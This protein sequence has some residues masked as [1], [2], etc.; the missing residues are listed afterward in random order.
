MKTILSLFI[1]LSGFSL[2]AQSRAAKFSDAKQQAKEGD[3]IAVLLHGSDWNP[4]GEWIKKN[5]WDQKE[6]SKALPNYRLTHID[7]LEY[8]GVKLKK[9]LQSVKD[10]LS[11]TKD[12]KLS[13]T[14]DQT[15]FHLQSDN[16]WLVKGQATKDEIYSIKF[17]SKES[18]GVVI[19]ETLGDENLVNEGAGRSENG[20]VCLTEIEVFV[21]GKQSSFKMAQSSNK[22]GE[23][24]INGNFSGNDYWSISQNSPK[25]SL[26]LL[27]KKKLKGEV[28]IK[29]HF[30]AKWAKHS[31]GRFRIRLDK[32]REFSKLLHR[33]ARKKAL[34]RKNKDFKEKTNIY[35]AIFLFDHQGKAYAKINTLS[36][37]STEASVIEQMKYLDKQRKKR[38][39]FWAEASTKT[40]TAKV[41]LLEKGLK[42]GGLIRHKKLYDKKIELIKKTDPQDETH[43]VRKYFFPLKKIREDVNKMIKK[44]KR[45]NAI[46]LLDSHV[47]HPKNTYVDK[48]KIQD[49][50]MQKFHIYKNWKGHEKKRFAVCR[51]IVSISAK[52]HTGIGAQGYLMM[53][54]EG[55]PVSI[56]HGWWSKHLKM[57][58]QTLKIDVDTFLHFD[59]AGQYRV[60]ISH[61][62]GSDKAKIHA[63]SLH[64]LGRKV[65]ESKRLETLEVKGAVEYILDFKDYQKTVTPTLHIELETVGGTDIKGKVK[66]FPLLD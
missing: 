60:T 5:I 64:S 19:L 1:M 3:K 9:A 62:G 45:E 61:N 59:H 56:N 43:Y 23:K 44:G 13:S 10:K 38:D 15:S 17:T 57:G 27:P 14:H 58:K 50:Q 8:E 55:G 33:Q 34:A 49:L 4:L 39:D 63:V 66:I 26:T 36:V 12:I 25:Q 47:K 24:V 18:V 46:K 42:V 41:H 6:F 51:D 16:S 48:E 31:L 20:S 40:G 35:P 22:G 28:E 53:H 11:A 30:K 54:N 52:T 37:E 32:G 2:W 21:N 65:A 29:L 7:D